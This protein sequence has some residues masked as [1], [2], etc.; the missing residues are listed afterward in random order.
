MTTTPATTARTHSPLGEAH[1]PQG[2]WRAIHGAVAQAS[3]AACLV[4]AVVTAAPAQG[5][6][7]AL[8][9][10]AEIT[11][12]DRASLNAASPQVPGSDDPTQ[13]KMLQ[14]IRSTA[15]R[16][17]GQSHLNGDAQE[18]FQI[19]QT[20]PRP[21]ALGLQADLHRGVILEH[22]QRHASEHRLVVRTLILV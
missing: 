7:R 19:T 17:A 1:A 12:I 20:P 10:P 21:L 6:V 8:P 14:K 11:D 16:D 9:T 18:E 13:E 5:S 3:G 4:L 15:Q 22:L 2:I